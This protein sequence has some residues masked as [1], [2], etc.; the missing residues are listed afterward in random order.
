MPN[1][2]EKISSGRMASANTATVANLGVGNAPS[3]MRQLAAKYHVSD[4]DIAAARERARELLLQT[5]IW[6]TNSKLFALE[7]TELDRALV[8]P[9]SGNPNNVLAAIRNLYLAQMTRFN[10]R[11]TTRR[12]HAYYVATE[13]ICVGT[14]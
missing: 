11:S 10:V 5:K 1:T 7:A 3:P 14:E 4:R 13:I 2:G 12:M 9:I 8:T 6:D